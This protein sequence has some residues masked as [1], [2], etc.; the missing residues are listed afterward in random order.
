[1]LLP[2]LFKSEDFERLKEIIEE[3]S[4][5]NLIIHKDRII[6][7]KAMMLVNGIEK[8]DFF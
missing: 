2:R 3:N 5:S 8:D 1:M 7:T 6:S 4:F